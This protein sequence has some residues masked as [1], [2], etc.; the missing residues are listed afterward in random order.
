ML[1]K[2][3]IVSEKGMLI[4]MSPFW[5]KIQPIIE[6]KTNKNFNV[7]ANWK[8]LNLPHLRILLMHRKGKEKIYLL[9][10]KLAML[11]NDK[12]ELIKSHYYF[13]NILL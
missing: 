13:F 1:V 11:V 5:S 12:E 10:Q 3:K 9:K 4:C 8:R 7:F 6:K 2:H